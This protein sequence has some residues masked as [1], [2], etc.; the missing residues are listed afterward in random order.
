MVT[1]DRCTAEQIKNDKAEN[2]V[3]DGPEVGEFGKVGK[4]QKLKS[5]VM[6][7][8][9]SG[10]GDKVKNVVTDGVK[11][12]KVG[13]SENCKIDEEMWSQGEERLYKSIIKGLARR[14]RERHAMV[15]DVEEEQ[16]QAVI[17]F[18]DITGKELPW[19]AVRKARELE[20]KYLHDLG[21]YEKVDEKEAVA[22]YGITPVDELV[23]TNKAFETGPMQIRSRM[24]AREFKSDDWPDLHAGTPPLEALKVEN[25]A[26]GGV[27]IE[28]C[29]KVGKSEN[30]KRI[31]MNGIKSW[32]SWQIRQLRNPRGE[33][34][35]VKTAQINV[36]GLEDVL[37]ESCGVD[38]EEKLVPEFD[39]NPGTTR[40]AKFSVLHKIV[41]PCLVGSGF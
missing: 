29:G 4:E 32:K 40:G 38:V 16:E 19:H 14:N 1:N 34:K 2:V 3:M 24:C 21:V 20:L 7:G 18:D 5:I 17:C 6:D 9:K 13:K 33:K 35:I 41:F 26:T 27:K 11:T 25:I 39:D 30:S 10:K 28:E 22:K 12:G 8:V 36:A 31:V 37:D 23:D 15:A